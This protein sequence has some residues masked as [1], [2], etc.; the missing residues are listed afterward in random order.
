MR[1]DLKAPCMACPFKRDS[2]AGYLGASSPEQFIETTMQDYSMPCHMTVDYENEHWEDDLDLAQQC[3]GAAIFFS[4]M[5]KLSRDHDRMKL[6][7]DTEAVFASTAEF[8][9]HHNKGPAR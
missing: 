9:A 8:I 7:P 2:L 1:S 3:T 4:N 6:P 5:C